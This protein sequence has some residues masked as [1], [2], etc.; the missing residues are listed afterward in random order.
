MRIPVALEDVAPSMVAATVAAEDQRFW[1]HPG[2]DPL[3]MLR[4]AREVRRNPS[5]ASTLTQQ[6]VRATYL[7]GQD[8]PLPLRKARE[9]LYAVALETRTSKRAGGQ[10]DRKS[11]GGGTGVYGRGRCG[12]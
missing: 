5:G 3:A 4:A 11:G 8:L 2:V 7:R 9:A 12:G 10:A 1:Q 6:L